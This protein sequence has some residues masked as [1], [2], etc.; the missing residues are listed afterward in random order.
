MNYTKGKWNTHKNALGTWTI[1]TDYEYIGEIDLI[2]ETYC[3]NE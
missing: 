2:I 1:S 3:L